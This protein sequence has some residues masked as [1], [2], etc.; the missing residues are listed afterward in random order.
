MSDIERFSLYGI[1]ID[2]PPGWEAR[3][4]IQQDPSGID[5]HLPGS[6]DPLIV[7]HMANFWLPEDCGDYGVEVAEVMG[8]GDVFVSLVEFGASSVGSRLFAHRGIPSPLDP[9]DFGSSR[10]PRLWGSLAGV[11]R[12]FSTADRA[13]CLH[14]VVGSRRGREVLSHDVNMILSGLDISRRSPGGVVAR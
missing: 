1:G 4:S 11:Q 2:V 3:L 5:P 9:A 12:F 10:I 13:F 14:A 7:L 8:P 6:P